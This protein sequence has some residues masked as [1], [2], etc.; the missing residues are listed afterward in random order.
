MKQVLAITLLGA[1]CT[2]WSSQP[3]R[4]TGFLGPLFVVLASACVAGGALRVARKEVDREDRLFLPGLLLRLGYAADDVLN[5][6]GWE[7]G[8]V[9][10]I[11]VL[12]AL[13]PSRPW[14]S[15]VLGVALMCY[16]LAVHRGESTIAVG[17]LRGQVRFLGLGLASLAL[18]SALATIPSAG[19]G[20]LSAGLEAVAALAA[21]A[22]VAL[23]LPL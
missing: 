22:A 17:F 14:H 16:L 12:E 10:C 21:L 20:G 18:A 23:A 9:V 6:V 3:L 19:T 5:A 11:I 1:A 8:S 13:H 2:F 4:G 7:S 15:G